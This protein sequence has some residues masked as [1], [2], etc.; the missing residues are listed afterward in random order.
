[1]KRLKGIDIYNQLGM[2][3]IEG[4]GY[5]LNIESHDNGAKGKAILRNSKGKVIVIKEYSNLI[6]TKEIN[7]SDAYD[8]LID[9]AELLCI[10]DLV[11]N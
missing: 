7:K 11:N 10:K 2:V 1:M 3:I 6:T 4:Y 8:F 5:R 9:L